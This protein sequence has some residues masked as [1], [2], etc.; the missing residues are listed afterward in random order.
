MKYNELDSNPILDNTLNYQYPDWAIETG[1]NKIVAYGDHSHKCPVYVK[2]VPPCTNECPAGEDIRGYHNIIRGIEKSP[3]ILKGDMTKWE[4]A[5]NLV[6][7][8]NPFPAVMGRVCPAPCEG[9]CNRQYL[10]ETVGINSVEHFIGN[11]GIENN[12][13][14]PAPGPDTKKHVAVIGS[15]PAGLSAAYQLRRKGHKVTIYEAQQKT[16]G[17]MRYGI[18]GYRVARSVLDAEIQRI[19]DLGVELKTGVK[20]GKDITFEEIEKKHDAVF[21]GTG[22]QVGRTPPVK[23]FEN[24]PYVSSA[25]KFLMEFESNFETSREKMTLGNEATTSMWLPAEPT[26]CRLGKNIA[27]IGDGDVAMDVV[28]L[29]MRLG[30]EAM[31]LSGVLREDM[32]CSDFEFIEAEH[33][34]AKMH[35]GVS[36]V[37]VVKDGD[38]V[39][40]L[41]CVK[42]EK[43]LKDE[44]G[45]NAAIPFLRYKPVAGSEF[46]IEA[47]MIVASIGQT[48]DLSGFESIAKTPFFQVDH[49]YLVKGK[50]NI[51]AGGD[52]IKID[53]ITTSVGQGR[54][55]AESIDLLLNAKELPSK[56]RQDIISYKKMHP[57]FYP[58]LPRVKRDHIKINTVKNNFAEILAS[59]Q[60]DMTA[61]ESERCLSCGLCFSCKQCQKYCPQE[62]ITYTKSKPVGETMFTIY[63]K[64]VGCHICAEVCPCG[65]ID[66][67]M[68]EGM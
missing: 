30:S 61:K 49:N 15:G 59:L 38:K 47:D 21:V 64:C 52:S 57:Y 18:M 55:A 63:E 58:P 29:A 11:Y 7:E 1:L 9:G 13:K 14:L 24:S 65:Y 44:D 2:R 40:K 54:K 22:A 51:F 41:K 34:G 62:A 31:I 23:G 12:L 66:M 46:E 60:A 3:E 45:F 19:L 53:L 50:T 35:F 6:V 32:N 16:G 56:P 10:D 42:M 27:V 20:I 48:T 28:R 37:E 8:T 36:V 26:S 68:G 67:G 25:V 39:V 43:K 4:A 17:M 5:W 33:E